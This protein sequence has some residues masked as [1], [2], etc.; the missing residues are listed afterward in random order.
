MIITIPKMRHGN[1]SKFA[2]HIQQKENVDENIRIKAS[3]EHNLRSKLRQLKE[4][5]IEL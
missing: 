4:Q 5:M 3:K 2:I 1:N